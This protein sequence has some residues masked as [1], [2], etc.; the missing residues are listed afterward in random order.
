MFILS[1][2]ISA[3]ASVLDILLS[4]LC[5]VV[6]VRALISWVNPDPSNPIVQ[7]LDKVCEPVLEPIRRRM[8]LNFRFGID[9]SPLIVILVIIF[10]KSFLIKSLFDLS[11][12]MRLR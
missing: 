7:F 11:V 1:N 10:L 2:F 5:W 8:P 9:I 12:W 6:V 4:I 3:S